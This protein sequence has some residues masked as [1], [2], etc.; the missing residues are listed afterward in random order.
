MLRGT[1]HPD[2]NRESVM[3]TVMEPPPPTPEQLAAWAEAQ[4]EA[5]REMAAA[6]AAAVATAKPSSAPGMARSSHGGLGKILLFALPPLLGIGGGVASTLLLPRP[7]LPEASAQ[8][9]NPTS[10]NTGDNVTIDTLI[11]AGAFTEALALCNR[12]R[13]MRPAALAYR[14]AVCLEAT[15]RLKQATEAYRRAESSEND[16]AAWA[17]ALL[18]QARCS[19]AAGDLGSAQAHLDRVFLRTGHPDCAGTHILEECLFLRARFNA[20]RLGPVRALDPFEPEAIAWP[21]L[22]GE[23]DKYYE[24]LPPDT[25]PAGSVGPAAPNA[26]AAHRDA[27]AAGGFVVTAHLAERPLPDLLRAIS[28]AA[29]LKLHLDKTISTALEKEVAAVDVESMP[30]EELLVALTGRFGVQ[31]KLESADL[32]ASSASA[33]GDHARVAR[34]F[35]RAIAGAPEHPLILSARIYLGNYEFLAGHTREAAKEYQLV[36]DTAPEASQVP[37]ALYNIGLAELRLNELPAARSRFVSLADRTPRSR[38]ADYGWWWVGRLHLDSGD[39]SAAKKAFRSA[40]SGRTRE[41]TS[42][43][44]IGI[45]ACE[46]LEGNDEAAKKVLGD[47]RIDSRETHAN[48]AK[49]FESLFRYRSTPTKGRREILL[50]A[51]HQTSNARGLGPCG[52]FL[53]GQVYRT[54]DLPERTAALYD[55]ATET[56]R[57]PLAVRMTFDAAQWYDLLDRFEPARQRYLAVAAADAKGLGA[58]A[59]FRLAGMA[60]RQ[61]HAEECIRRCRTLIDRPGMDRAE[62]LG[63]M[64]RAYELQRNYRLAADC[65]AGRVPVE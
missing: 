25:T 55:A 53:A 28:T 5:E 24:W 38:W 47:Y 2:S 15:G 26:I 31:W 21:A 20:L 8:V 9:A 29:G 44:A 17:R 23:L 39:E 43:A 62:V 16:Q 57:G 36:L 19:A 48:L 27:N 18:G 13:N 46:V 52:L 3:S 33:A 32:T 7:A 11:R 1:V 49:L 51:L 35:Q 63:L 10:E 37:H 54:L 58:H 12:E 30:I 41:V 64:G 42:A 60:Y 22:S 34:S 4:A 65:F 61:R 45:C 14:E 50:D 6:D 40:I 56:I 59:E